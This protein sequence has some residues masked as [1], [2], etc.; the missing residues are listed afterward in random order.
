[1][2]VDS[3]GLFRTFIQTLCSKV[4]KSNG[5]TIVSHVSFE[6]IVVIAHISGFKIQKKIK[7]EK[8]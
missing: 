1:M 7:N 6:S 4:V 8:V 2:Q 5:L 3:F